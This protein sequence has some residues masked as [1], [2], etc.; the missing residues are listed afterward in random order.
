MEVIHS[1]AHLLFSRAN[2]LTKPLTQQP[3]RSCVFV[4]SGKPLGAKSVTYNWHYMWGENAMWLPTLAA[5]TS[6]LLHLYTSPLPSLAVQQLLL[7]INT[8]LH[9]C[10]CWLV[11]KCLCWFFEARWNCEGFNGNN[12]VLKFLQITHPFNE[13]WNCAVVVILTWFSVSMQSEGEYVPWF[14]W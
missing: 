13:P 9:A 8:S 7:Y 10:I 14:Y 3:W 2:K 11:E 12:C 4:A 1:R 5:P 6:C